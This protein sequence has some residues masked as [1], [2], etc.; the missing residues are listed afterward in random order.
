MNTSIALSR[1]FLSAYK[2]KVGIT[3]GLEMSS[4]E[5]V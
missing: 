1:L 3:F 2:T 4:D 5:E